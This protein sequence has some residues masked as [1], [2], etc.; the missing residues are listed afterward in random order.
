MYLCISGNYQQNAHE[1]ERVGRVP[2]LK[3]TV[4]TPKMLVSKESP[5]FQGAPYFPGAIRPPS[6]DVLPGLLVNGCFFLQV[7]NK[8]ETL[9]QNMES[10]EKA[11]S[12]TVGVKSYVVVE[13]LKSL[14]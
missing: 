8:S 7:K 2:S 14:F 13:H 9:E 5:A 1:N 12:F 11:N 3:L 10:L 6:A 4:R